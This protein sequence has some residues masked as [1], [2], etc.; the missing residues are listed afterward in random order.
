MT[1]AFGSGAPDPQRHA[2]LVATLAAAFADDP[3]LAWILPDPAQRA[4][5]L[6]GFFRWLV[7]AHATDG[8]ILATSDAQ[9]A[10]LWRRPGQVHV[11]ADTHL[12]DVIRLIP[13]FGLRLARAARLGSAVARH[14]P[15]GEDQLYLRYIGV[16]PAAQGRGLGGAL[17]RAGLAEA[18]RLGV[19]AC[20]ETAKPA[21]VA[22]YQ[23]FGFRIVAEWDAPGGG[24]H[25][26]TMQRPA[27]A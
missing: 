8:T 4:R 25:F 15:P 13:V 26:W 27:A 14:V 16:A 6:P 24:P 22:L 21:N 2:A 12:A 1:P 23:A 7:D 9:A 10:S 17:L 11:D 19:A 18:D 20:L 3:A 5:R